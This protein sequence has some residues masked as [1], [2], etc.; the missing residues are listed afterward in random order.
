MAKNL[1]NQ[2]HSPGIGDRVTCENVYF[3]EVEFPKPVTARL[4]IQFSEGLSLLVDNE[5]SVNLAARFITA[6]RKYE[7][8]SH[9]EGGKR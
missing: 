7:N 8:G 3:S 9:N 5:S 1:S 6:F 4:V 2:N